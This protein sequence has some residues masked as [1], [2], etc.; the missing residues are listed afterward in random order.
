MHDSLYK[1]SHHNVELITLLQSYER[2]V[3]DIA[4]RTILTDFPCR[5]MKYEKLAQCLKFWDTDQ[6]VS[7]AATVKQGP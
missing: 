2:L 4:M 1:Q 7:Q 6:K 5:N 3:L